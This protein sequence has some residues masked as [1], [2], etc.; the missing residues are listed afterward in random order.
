MAKRTIGR[1]KF[2]TSPKS[3]LDI[4]AIMYAKHL[5]EGAASPLN[6]LSDEDWGDTGPKIAVTRQNHDTAETA[7]LQME[8]AYR[9]RDITLPEVEQIVRTSIGLLKKVYSKN[10]KRLGEWGISVDDTPQ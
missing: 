1:V 7:K 8:M 3:I 10:P 6:L 2:A 9:Q 5:A 4:A